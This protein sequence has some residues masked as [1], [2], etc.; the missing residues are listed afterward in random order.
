MG[1]TEEQGPAAMAAELRRLLGEKLRLAMT[2]TGGYELDGLADAEDDDVGAESGG[3][4]GAAVGGFGADPSIIKPWEIQNT[5]AASP[6]GSRRKMAEHQTS[7][8]QYEESPRPSPPCSPPP[9]AI[10]GDYPLPPGSP[11][12]NEAVVE[13]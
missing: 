12:K 2:E 9:F 3:S 13:Q 7:G 5:R 6:S 1:V 4:G 11:P 10:G 8:G